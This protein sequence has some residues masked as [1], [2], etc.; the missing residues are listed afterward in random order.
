M[1]RAHRSCAPNSTFYQGD[2][3][4]WGPSALGDRP[5]FQRTSLTLKAHKDPCAMGYAM[6]CSDTAIIVCIFWLKR[7]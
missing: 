6:S 3:P 5:V 7:E 4:P 1:R 2:E